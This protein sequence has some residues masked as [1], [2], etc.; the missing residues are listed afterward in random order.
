MA[1]MGGWEL[2]IGIRDLLEAGLHFGH[3]SRRW[4]PKMKRFI[5]DKRNGIHVIDLAKSL[6]QLKESCQ[7]IY[8][9]VAGGRK[10]L[11]VGTKKQIKEAVEELAQQSGQFYVT[12]RWLGGTLTNSTTVRRSVRRMKELEKQEQ[13]GTFDTLAKKEVARLRNELIRLQR[14]LSGIAD[15]DNPPGAVFVVDIN[16]E[17][18]AVAEANKLKVPVVAMIDTN[19]DPDL[20]DYPIPGN[21]D[22]IRAVKLVVGV[23]GDA[24][25]KASGEYE[26]TL[27]EQAQK[28][29]EAKAAAA[30]APA[31]QPAAK[32]RPRRERKTGE[33]PS[34][35]RTT[36]TAAGKPKEAA[37]IAPSEPSPPASAP[38]AVVATETV[39]DQA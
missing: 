28:R 14:N 32:D 11:F 36:T 37:K 29:E 2:D 5:F 39:A 30:A 18:I 27:S 17:A 6:A 21:D 22:A 1:T 24:I 33:R 23:I 4:N 34:A 16:R 12:N 3:Q 31:R 9:T 8:D 26:K 19:C 20:V 25:R 15:M 35:R 13:D 10:I 7:F 38:E